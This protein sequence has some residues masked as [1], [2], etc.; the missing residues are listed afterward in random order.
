MQSNPGACGGEYL[1]YLE[2][3]EQQFEDLGGRHRAVYP[4]VGDGAVRRR[5]HGRL[6]G[7]KSI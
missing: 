3:I 2:F 6:R 4:D 5:E 1:T 7:A